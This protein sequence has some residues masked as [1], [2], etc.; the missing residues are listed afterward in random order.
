MKIRRSSVIQDLHICVR[1]GDRMVWLPDD[2]R[3]EAVALSCRVDFVPYAVVPSWRDYDRL[4][5]SLGNDSPSAYT[6]A[7]FGCSNGRETDSFE[8]IVRNEER[9][10]AMRL[11]TGLDLHRNGRR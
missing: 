3:E 11:L 9:V 6:S 7:R 8:R 4:F 2:Q 1:E 5:F 10:A